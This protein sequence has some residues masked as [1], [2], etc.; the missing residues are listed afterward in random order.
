MKLNKLSEIK[1]VQVQADNL[2][3]SPKDIVHCIYNNSIN[4]VRILVVKA[5]RPTAQSR[6]L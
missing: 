2:V 5:P 3:E 6:L 1:K 4:I